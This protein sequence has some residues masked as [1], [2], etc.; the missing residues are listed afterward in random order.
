MHTKKK[1]MTRCV[2]CDTLIIIPAALYKLKLLVLDAAA[3]IWRALSMKG[4]RGL[5]IFH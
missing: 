3:F 1:T 5:W 4:K 2:F